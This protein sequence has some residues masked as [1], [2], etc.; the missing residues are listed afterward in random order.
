MRHRT[1]TTL[2][3]AYHQGVPHTTPAARPG[4]ANAAPS[5]PTLWCLHYR[6]CRALFS[7]G[8][9]GT[10]PPVYPR[11]P[12]QATRT[13]Q[14]GRGRTKPT[15]APIKPDHATTRATRRTRGHVATPSMTAKAPARA[16]SPAGPESSHR[17]SRHPT[18]S[19]NRARPTVAHDPLNH[20]LL[21]YSASGLQ[22]QTAG[23]R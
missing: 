20:D 5:I 21:V 9:V 17:P 23:K 18:Q 12:A 3:V 4:G 15:H 1:P 6:V 8:W 2:P 14:H 19:A 11:P 7:C 10:A 22:G 13:D 16:T